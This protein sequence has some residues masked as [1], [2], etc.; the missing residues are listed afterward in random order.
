MS[1]SFEINSADKLETYEQLASALQALCQTEPDAGANMANC[2]ALL[3]STL[4]QVNWAGFYLLKAGELVLASFQGKLACTRIKLGRGVCGA[5]AQQNKVVVV[6]DVHAFEGHIACD[7][8]T[9][10][11]IV[12]PIC[13]H[14]RL[15]GV[16]DI[17]SPIENRFD[18]TDRA[19]LEKIVS[20]LVSALERSNPIQFLHTMIRVGHLERS[21]QFYQDVF[22][23]QLVRKSD[24]PDGKFSLAFLRLGDGSLTEAE[25]ELT[26]NWGVENYDLGKGYGHIALSVPS[27]ESLGQKLASLG[28]T[29]SW[30]PS[31]TPSGKGGMAFIKD[32]DGYAIEL[33]ERTV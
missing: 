18:E 25:L 26:Y 13:V 7:A 23:F 6:P 16:L 28:L 5:A 30:G 20:I 21:I 22:G 19:G 14:G 4:P 27:L 24:Y 32:P 31:T 10:S 29:F 2:A 8:D 3:Y 17:D 9:R 1:L 12:L 11:E 33:L 15:Y